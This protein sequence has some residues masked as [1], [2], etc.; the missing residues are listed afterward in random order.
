MNKKLLILLLINV[1]LFAV[2]MPLSFLS[3]FLAGYG[4]NSS[5]AAASW[6]LYTGFVI[7]H[8]VLNL[9]LLYKL[10]L[11]NFLSIVVSCIMI[12]IFYGIVAWKYTS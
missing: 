11:L 8:L 7:A 10:K 4:S 2:S 5:H 3:A 9:L 12:V 6:R 1:G